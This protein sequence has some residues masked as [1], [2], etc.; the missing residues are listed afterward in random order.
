[1]RRAFSPL[2][3]HGA[4]IGCDG[5]P[6]RREPRPQIPARHRIW[7][8]QSPGAAAKIY[9]TDPQDAN[10]STGSDARIALRATCPLWLTTA[11]LLQMPVVQ[12][13]EI[14]QKSSRNGRS[15]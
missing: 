11:S 12:V 1:E 15:S 14:T 13:Q 7:S 4:D 2:P 9:C 3:A 8:R 6:Y 10:P 5:F